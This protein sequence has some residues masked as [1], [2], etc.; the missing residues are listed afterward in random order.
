[1]RSRFEYCL[2]EEEPSFSPLPATYVIEEAGEWLPRAR[3]SWSGGIC[4]RER[5]LS[6]E[7]PLFVLAEEALGDDG[8]IPDR[9]GSSRID[10]AFLR[11][12]S[13]RRVSSKYD[14]ERSASLILAS[15][16]LRTSGFVVAWRRSL[17]ASRTL[18]SVSMRLWTSCI[19]WSSSSGISVQE[20]YPIPPRDG[21][22]ILYSL[23]RL[24]EWTTA[25]Y[26]NRRSDLR[27]HGL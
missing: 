25:H 11:A 27:K 1:M 23:C 9:E 26:R 5:S 13:S 14:R 22:L 2:A 8:T 21:D 24:N 10:W 20:Y 16:R 6:E 17:E 3:V 4:G 7:R 19:F 12:C 18:R 15:L